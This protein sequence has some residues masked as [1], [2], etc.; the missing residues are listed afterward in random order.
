MRQPLR[1]A[2]AQ[3]GDPADESVRP[4]T[5]ASLLS[6]NKAKSISQFL[7]IYQYHLTFIRHYKYTRPVLSNMV[8]TSHTWL[9]STSIVTYSV[10]MCSMYKAH[11]RS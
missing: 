11:T 8:G 5:G 7:L 1:R 9:F 10:E 6:Q 2:K 3:G 4:L